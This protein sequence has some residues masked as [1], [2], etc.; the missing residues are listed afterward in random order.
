MPK[1]TLSP[2]TLTKAIQKGIDYLAQTQRPS[3]EFATYTS[4]RLDM[5][6]AEEYPKSV[7]ITTFVIHA[8]SCLPPSPLIKQ[9]QRRAGDFLLRE[10]EDNGAWHYDGRRD[11]WKIPLDLDDTCCATAALFILGQRPAL[12]LYTH[13]WQNE[14]APGGPYY[15]W[16]GVDHTEDSILAQD[17]DILVNANILFCGG[18]LNLSLPGTIDYVQQVI[19]NE[20]YQA[21]SIYCI[22]PHF[23]IYVISRAYGDGNVEALA[24]TMPIMQDYVLTRL[25]RPRN[26]PV[27]FNLAC[28]AVA[29]L[30]LQAGLSL[31]EPYLVALLVGQK[32]DGH[33]PAW[34]AYLSYKHHYDGAPAL[35]TALALEALSKYLK[36]VSLS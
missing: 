35:T 8:L 15:T 21:Q 9:I 7:Y 4:P 5:A 26:E 25:V 1:Q 31:I 29:L 2:P 6:D 24:P 27:T 22:A 23:P 14:V 32:S 13:L 20:G 18:L 34:A 36:R 28:L 12:S 16:I 10:Q 11:E 19:S 17:V 30:N 3:G 33:W